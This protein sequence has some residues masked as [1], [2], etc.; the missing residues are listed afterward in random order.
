MAWVRARWKTIDGRI[1]EWDYQHGHV[2]MYDRRGEHL[3]GFDAITG[4]MIKDPD[5]T[6]HVEP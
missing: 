1:F 5:N 4:T 3:G 2:E 6:R